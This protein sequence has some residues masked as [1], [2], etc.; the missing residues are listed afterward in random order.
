[1]IHAPVYRDSA[2]IGV[3]TAAAWSPY[4]DRG[5]GY[6][7]LQSA[8]NAEPRNA[9]VIGFSDQDPHPCEIIDLPF[10]DPDKRI[11]RGLETPTV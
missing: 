4:L 5:I 3:V 10:Y 8:E 7:R 11:P 9:E 1:L 6:V 2:E